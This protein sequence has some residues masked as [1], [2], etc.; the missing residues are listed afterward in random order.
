MRD[1]MSLLDQVIAFSGS[2]LTGEDVTRV[3]GVADRKV[4]HDLAAALLAGDAAGC[5]RIIESVAQHGFDLGHVAKDVLYHLRNLVVAKV[6]AKD[7]SESASLRELLDMADEEVRD[8]VE[9]ASRAEID[10]LTRCFQG[11]SRA[12][13]DIVRGGQ[14]RMVLEMA[15]V[16]IARRPPLLPLDELLARVGELERRLGGASP[17]P[18]PR[19]GGGGSGRGSTQ[20]APVSTVSPPASGDKAVGRTHGALALVDSSPRE[21]VTERSPSERP[22]ENMRPVMVGRSAAA[23]SPALAD[24]RLIVEHL[25]A[26]QPA[27]ASVFEHAM[28]VEVGPERVLLGFES[29]SGFLALRANERE[30]LEALTTAVRGFYGVNTAVVIDPTP[31]PAGGVKTVAAADAERRSAELAR[32]RA[33]VQEHPVVKEAL[34][35]F[36][37][38]LRDVRLPDTE[39]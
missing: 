13:D 5:V 15:L 17:G 36:G 23:P 28:P 24:W 32:A 29:G 18:S 10:D 22:L 25:R 39:R 4:L 2:K 14:P 35:V 11:F 6:C 12:F 20:V 37:A 26:A 34:R 21:R 3:L 8:I 33:A 1:A 16:R 27:L 38:Q 30:V 19:G 9:L 7:S 31:R